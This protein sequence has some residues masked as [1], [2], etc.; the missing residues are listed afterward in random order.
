M[1]ARLAGMLLQKSPEGLVVDVQGIGYEVFVSLQ[2]FTHLPPPGHPVDLRIHTH[3]REDALHLYGFLE[4]EERASFRLLLG[5]AGIGPKLALSVL[6]GIPHLEFQRA[7]REGDLARLVAIPGVGRKTAER[8]VVELRD[9]VV[10]GSQIIEEAA[11]DGY[12]L[13]KDAVSALVG[14]GYKRA[15]A[16][17]AVEAAMRNKHGAIEGLLRDALKSLGM[18]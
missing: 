16:E 12:Q 7:V 15:E 11:G 18:S 2:A 3:L 9:K 10:A 6:S 17:R 4:E 5:V 13:R 14:L 8:I 1:I